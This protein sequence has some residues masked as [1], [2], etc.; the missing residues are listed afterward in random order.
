MAFSRR[1]AVLITITLLLFGLAVIWWT[2]GTG[3]SFAHFLYL[4]ILFAAI[5]LGVPG[6]V[7]AALVAGGVVA[8][9]PADAAAGAQQ[10]LLSRGVHVTSF[11]AAAVST[12]AVVHHLRVQR[13]RIQNG[14]VESVAALVN[15]LEASDD[16][17]AG[18][19]V[20]V[21][22]LSVAIGKTMGLSAGQL[23]VLRDGAVLHDVGKVGVPHHIL[24]KPGRLTAE[25]FSIVRAHPTEGDR[26]LGPFSHPHAAEIRDLVRHHHERLDGSGY[27][28][29]LKGEQIGLMARI[30]MVADVYDAVTSPRPYRTAMHPQDAVAMLEDEV[31][32]GRLDGDVVGVLRRLVL[33]GVRLVG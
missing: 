16:C 21:S 31:R 9:L 17:T 19:T 3:G 26:I 12:G 22:D 4:P 23:E 27:P 2:G 14:F 25:E 18:H 30:L 15:A 29:G 13:V 5:E 11:M 10:T 32:A 8:C 24:N 33:D 28:D 20:R 6:G 1:A 7:G